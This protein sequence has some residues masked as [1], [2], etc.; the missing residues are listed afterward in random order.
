MCHLYFVL[1][2]GI[3]YSW[4]DDGV[5]LTTGWKLLIERKEEFVNLWKS[6][7]AKRQR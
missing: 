7:L 3:E 5:A 6:L 2:T 4:I 1:V